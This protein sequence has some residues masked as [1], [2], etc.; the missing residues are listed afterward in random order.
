VN[1]GGIRVFSL[2]I[3]RTATPMQA[4][5][6]RLEGRRYRPARLMQPDDVASM[7]V[8]ALSMPRTAEVTDI[9]MRPLA[10]LEPGP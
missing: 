7:V 9:I 1:Q 10:K 6:H 8:H 3:G 4:E 5:V 2:F